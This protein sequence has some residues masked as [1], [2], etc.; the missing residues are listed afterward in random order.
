[1]CFVVL[2]AERQSSQTFLT[3]HMDSIPPRPLGHFGSRLIGQ[4]IGVLVTNH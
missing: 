2:R 1:M 3:E 4:R